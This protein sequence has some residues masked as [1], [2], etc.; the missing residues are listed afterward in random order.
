MD[1]RPASSIAQL[2]LFE[3]TNC[4]DPA[5]FRL[6]IDVNDDVVESDENNNRAEY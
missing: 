2:E 4:P 5:K 1:I 3:R 6:L